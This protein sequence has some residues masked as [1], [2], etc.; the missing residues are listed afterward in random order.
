[1]HSSH[2][3]ESGWRGVELWETR[4]DS[5]RFYAANSA[6]PTCRRVCDRLNI[7]ISA[8]ECAGWIS[9]VRRDPQPGEVLRL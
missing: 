8:H 3:T 9:E 2:E 5:G 4:E 6:P 7:N 1:M